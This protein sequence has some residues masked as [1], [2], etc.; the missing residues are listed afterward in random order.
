MNRRSFLASSAGLAASS[1]FAQTPVTELPPL[2]ERP[3]Q[4]P[5]VEIINPRGLV[6]LSYI[7]DDATCLVNLN[8][9]ASPHFY[10]AFGSQ[11]RRRDPCA[12]ERS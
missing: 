11:G 3:T 8:K 12:R 1:A 5:S 10:E 7:I 9:F 6:P 2:G 4:D